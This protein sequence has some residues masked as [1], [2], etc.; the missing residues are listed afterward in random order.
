MIDFDIEFEASLREDSFKKV[1]SLGDV[2]HKLQS[3]IP[4]PRKAEEVDVD[5][6]ILSYH[7]MLNDAEARNNTFLELLKKSMNSSVE[8]KEE[9]YAEFN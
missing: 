5:V 6:F 7:T 8:D 1:F 2:Y 3:I 4:D 9:R